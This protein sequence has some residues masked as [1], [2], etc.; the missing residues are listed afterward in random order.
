MSD[1]IGKLEMEI[2]ELKRD[3]EELG[4]EEKY[5]DEMFDKLKPRNPDE[6]GKAL[7]EFWK[8]RKEHGLRR[9][10][11]KEELGFK[12]E[13]LEIKKDHLKKIKE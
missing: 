10:T 12:R 5:L 7:L 8:N 9:E 6:L 3:I 4:E 11:I 2:D 13:Q 1:E